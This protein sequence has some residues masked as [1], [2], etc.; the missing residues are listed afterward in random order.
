MTQK[1]KFSFLKTNRQKESRNDFFLTHFAVTASIIFHIHFASSKFIE[2]EQFTH[3]K[4]KE[5]PN[6]LAIFMFNVQNKRRKFDTK[7]RL[8]KPTFSVRDQRLK[9]T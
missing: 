4:K 5:N 9:I 6:F 2:R 7:E 8:K 1:N 3:K